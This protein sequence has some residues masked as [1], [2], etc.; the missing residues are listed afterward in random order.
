[1]RDNWPETTIDQVVTLL[2][3]DL[4]RVVLHRF[5]PAEP[6]E[7]GSSGYHDPFGHGQATWE[8]LRWTSEEREIGFP[9]TELVPSWT[10]R[11]PPGGWLEVELRA[12]TA[13]GT[14]T[15]WYVMGRW[16]E[17]DADIHR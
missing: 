10:A 17:G 9:A 12:R 16:A 1:M 4:G 3:A 15:R 13:D 5:A 7:S 8:F 14:L 11:T 2:P 6:Y